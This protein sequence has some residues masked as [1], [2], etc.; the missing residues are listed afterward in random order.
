[1]RAEKTDCGSEMSTA[2]SSSLRVTSSGPRLRAGSRAAAGALDRE[3]LLDRLDRLRAILPAFAEELA[4]SRRQTA[5]PRVENRG[6]LEVR[7]LQSEST[8]GS[9]SCT[10]ASRGGRPIRGGWS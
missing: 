3:H 6:L 5:A 2:S 1:M 9:S 8:I 4:S 7:R 10:P